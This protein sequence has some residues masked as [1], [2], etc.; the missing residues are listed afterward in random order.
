MLSSPT[1][2]SEQTLFTKVDILP[3]DSRWLVLFSGDPSIRMEVNRL[4]FPLIRAATQQDVPNLLQA[5]E[6]AC[7]K[8]LERRIQGKILSRYG[9]DRERL[10]A[11]GRKAL[12]RRIFTRLTAQI[13]AMSLETEFLVAGFEPSGRERLFCVGDPGETEHLEHVGVHAIGAGASVALGMLCN[14]YKPTLAMPEL[15]YRL[16]E[17]KFLAENAPGV[18]KKTIVSVLQRD[19]KKI[20]WMTSSRSETVRRLWNDNRP[21]IPAGADE[22]IKQALI[23]LQWTG[24]DI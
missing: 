6:A 22:A 7:L 2:G 11:E 9:I 10:F 14:T 13:E 12:G 20:W 24:E 18:G 3:P 16:C 1:M 23:E 4:A 15:V 19:P 17:A 8:V 21:P 5:Y